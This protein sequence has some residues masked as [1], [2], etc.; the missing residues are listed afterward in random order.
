LARTIIK[1]VTDTP[2]ELQP[3]IQLD[4]NMIKDLAVIKKV[5]FYGDH[6]LTNEEKGSVRRLKSLMDDIYLPPTK[7]ESKM[8]FLTLRDAFSSICIPSDM[9]ENNL[10]LLMIEEIIKGQ[11]I[12]PELLSPMEDGVFKSV[13]THHTSDP[14][15]ISMVKAYTGLD[16][17]NSIVRQ[18]E[19]VI[20]SMFEKR[21]RYD[22]NFSAVNA[23]LAQ[24]KFNFEMNK[25]RMTGDTV[26]E[27]LP[28][29]RSRLVYTENQLHMSQEAMGQTYASIEKAYHVDLLNYCIFDEGKP[30]LRRF[31][32]R[33]DDDNEELTNDSTI[34]TVELPKT[35][36]FLN[37]P[38]DQLS[39]AQ[40]WSIFFTKAIDPQYESLIKQ[41][42][43]KVEAIDMA[44]TLVSQISK[45]PDER[46]A[47]LTR[48]IAELNYNDDIQASK[49]IGEEIGID[50][51]VKI[52]RVEGVKDLVIEM[53]K[54]G[55]T[56]AE[57]KK[58]YRY[59]DDDIK[60]LR[61]EI[62]KGNTP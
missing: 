15:R 23:A 13:M 41:I 12:L 42:A 51:G 52:G 38:V 9:S 55:I 32:Y 31:T 45:D 20:A 62:A 28:H 47:F 53:L 57:I 35:D 14:I 34:I 48:H 40:M 60:I 7:H 36:A 3:K 49:E 44:I 61:A 2:E 30:F 43:M 54:N 50:K 37:T 29:I 56:D 46:A 22:V 24:F 16:I 8:V 27:G 17:S 5:L 58:Y 6:P 11:Y 18:N 39:L 10:K 21:C 19:P 4:D 1:G 26:R 33:A 25:S 59:T